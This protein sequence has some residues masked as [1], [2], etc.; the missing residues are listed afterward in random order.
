MGLRRDLPSPQP[1]TAA[2]LSR[3]WGQECCLS[4][5]GGC[6][7]PPPSAAPSASPYSPV[8]LYSGLTG[9]RARGCPEG[10][11]LGQRHC[12][13]SGENLTPVLRR[14]R[15]QF[16]GAT[17]YLACTILC[18]G[19]QRGIA[20]SEHIVNTLLQSLHPLPLFLAL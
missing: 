6:V 8:T 4:P 10:D 17:S 18:S 20:G 12:P 11:V 7:P 2:A 16:Y 14:I 3:V 5:E 15:S 9:P 19:A 1:W 13:S